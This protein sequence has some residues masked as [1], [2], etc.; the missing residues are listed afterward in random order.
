VPP[1]FGLGTFVH[2][3]PFVESSVPWPTATQ[4]NDPGAQETANGCQVG[5]V[6]LVV[7]SQKAP[8]HAYVKFW[9]TLV[10][11]PTAA[12]DAT[13]EHETATRPWEPPTAYDQLVLAAAAAGVK[14]AITPKGLVPATTSSETTA[15]ESR[16]IARACLGLRPIPIIVFPP[17]AIGPGSRFRRGPANAYAAALQS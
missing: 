11:L 8:F 7:D 14:A 4:K 15:T 12:Q 16:M 3:F 17:S 1:V 6:G 13:E 9:A 2:P 5:A 10:R